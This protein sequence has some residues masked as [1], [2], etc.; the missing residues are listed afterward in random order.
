MRWTKKRGGGKNQFSIKYPILNDKIFFS[1]QILFL[2]FT[3]EKSKSEVVVAIM[4]FHPLCTHVPTP[5]P[6]VISG[7]DRN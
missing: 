1:K 3:Y 4:Q 7:F 2:K 5:T 6:R